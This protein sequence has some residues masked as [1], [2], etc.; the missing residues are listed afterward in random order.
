MTPDLRAKTRREAPLHQ[1]SAMLK[2]LQ[3]VAPRT[4]DTYLEG[5]AAIRGWF[6]AHG[7]T[8]RDGHSPPAWR[9]LCDWNLESGG[10]MIHHPLHPHYGTV[11]TT[12]FRLLSWCFCVLPI[13]RGPRWSKHRAP[14][15][16]QEARDFW[17]R[18]ARQNTNMPERKPKSRSGN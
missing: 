15:D 3:G 2:Q 5:E 7:F 13:L 11:W 6:G 12:H 1:F 16:P 9:T 17:R 8:G 4:A 10:M 18:F 14:L